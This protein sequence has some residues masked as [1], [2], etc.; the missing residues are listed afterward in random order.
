MPDVSAVLRPTEEAEKLGYDSV[1]VG[2]RL[3]L[4]PRLESLSTLGAVTAKTMSLR[5]GTTIMLGAH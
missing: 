5:L 3:L 2:Q 4:S 1:W